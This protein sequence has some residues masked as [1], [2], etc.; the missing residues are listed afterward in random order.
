MLKVSGKRGGP[1][2]GVISPPLSNI[3]LNEVDKM[4]V[5]AKE[6]TRHGRYTYIEYARFADDQVILIDGYRTWDWLARAAYKRLLEELTKLDVRINTEKTLIVDLTR[7]E[8]FSFLGFDL[9]RRKT[10]RES[11]GC[12]LRRES[13]LEAHCSA[14][15]GK[16]LDALYPS[17]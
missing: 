9:C 11:G 17:L 3:Y 8:S 6:V 14:N 16:S 7:D 15:S 2:G 12:A 4:L 13:K 1:Q 5:R 10:R